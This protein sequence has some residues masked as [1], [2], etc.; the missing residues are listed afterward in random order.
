MANHLGHS[1]VITSFGESHGPVIG[2]VIDGFPSGFA[3]DKEHIQAEL[4]RRRPGQSAISTDRNES[5]AFDIVSGVFEGKTTGA[6]IAILIPNT[7]HQSKDYDALK[8]VYRPG[9]ADK[10]YDDKYGHRDHLGGGRSSARI[11]AGWV[12]A[13]A[14][15]KQYIEHFYNITI[16]SVVSSVHT[17]KVVNVF[18]QNWTDAENNIVRCPDPEMA[19]AMIQLI[20]EMKNSGDS[21]GGTISTRIKN[22]PAGIGEPV[23]DKLN[24]E[25]AKAMFSIN[26]VK[27]IEFGAGFEGASLKGSEYNNT[28]DKINNYEGGINAGIS[29]GQDIEFNTAFKPVS[30]IKMA[31]KAFNK[32]GDIVDLNIEGRHDPC[33]LPRAVPIVEAMAALVI[34]DHLL[35]N[36]KYKI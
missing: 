11:T 9:H 10:V 15:A 29:T 34:A 8:S 12:A 20:A 28:A 26:A 6:P 36:L 2:V 35:L 13:G 33:V 1:L 24:A 22:C 23:F 31:Q 19:E 4:N 14:L 7:S 21:V 17:I 5:D 32:G 25:L 16:Q 3:I 18:D 27:G 30:S